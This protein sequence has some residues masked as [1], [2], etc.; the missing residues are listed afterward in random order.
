MKKHFLATE[1][2][3]ELA[4]LNFRSFLKYKKVLPVNMRWA[5]ALGK[6]LWLNKLEDMLCQKLKV[7]YQ[8]GEQREEDVYE[9]L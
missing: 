4:K 2:E 9:V 8:K 6:I 5:N 1:D 3:L 7:L